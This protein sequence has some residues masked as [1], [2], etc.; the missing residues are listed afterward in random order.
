[1][2]EPADVVGRG[3]LTEEAVGWR[4]CMDDPVEAAAVVVERLAPMAEPPTG[5]DVRAVLG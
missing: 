4:D 3:A 2:V 5:D 1:M